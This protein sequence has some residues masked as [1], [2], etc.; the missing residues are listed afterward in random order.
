MFQTEMASLA[1]EVSF[2]GAYTIRL[3]KE[4]SHSPKKNYWLEVSHMPYA[5]KHKRQRIKVEAADLDSLLID[6]A[7]IKI[8]ALPAEVWGLDG[9]TYE[10]TFNQGMNGVTY[11]WWAEAPKGYESL[12]RFAKELEKLAWV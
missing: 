7:K 2:E 10:L 1:T 11:H 6:L 4:Q 8:P 5:M 3:L 9:A 12:E